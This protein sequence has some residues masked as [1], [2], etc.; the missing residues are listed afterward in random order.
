M[1]LAFIKKPRDTLY[2][3]DSDLDIFLNVPMKPNETSFCLSPDGKYV[4]LISEGCT[5]I[6][7]IEVDTREL[8]SELYR[9][10]ESKELACVGFC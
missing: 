5:N 10:N 4:A 2:V 7:I 9:G 6:R 1:R 3:Y 8:Y